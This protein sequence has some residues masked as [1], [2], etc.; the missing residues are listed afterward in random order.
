[1]KALRSPVSALIIALAAKS[2]FSLPQMSDDKDFWRLDPEYKEGLSAGN[3]DLPIKNKDDI[4]KLSKLIKEEQGKLEEN[5]QN[6]Q[7]NRRIISLQFEAMK[8]YLDQMI[9]DSINNVKK[10][11][12]EMNANFNKNLRAITKSNEE[13]HQR[14]EAKALENVEAVARKLIEEKSAT[15]ENMET[16]MKQH[17]DLHDTQLA[18][19]GEKFRYG[20]KGEVDFRISRESVS[21]AGTKIPG[22]NVL[23]SGGRFQVPKGGDGIYE[24]GLSLILDTVHDRSKTG[25]SAKFAFESFQK[26][27]TKVHEETL[28]MSNV[29]TTDRDRVPA[30]RTVLFD[31]VEGDNVVVKQFVLNAETTYKL[32]LCVH[33]VQPS[34]PQEGWSPIN[35]TATLPALR[36]DQTYKKQQIDDFEIGTLSADV[37]EPSIPKT[38]PLSNMEVVVGPLVVTA[39]NAPG[40]L[41]ELSPQES[42]PE[43]GSGAHV[44]DQFD[45]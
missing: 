1:M 10:T 4:T 28:L 36:T 23:R 22:S 25:A 41:F 17:E 31:L 6:D 19:C 34:P 29:G 24:F 40:S 33:L 27:R 7:A 14:L 35:K 11:F 39:K 20:G 42:T 32:T 38:E 18:I 15:L 12:A 13:N 9:G 2:T 45:D 3:Q 26:G 37:E 5:V 16:R 43:F 44:P 30:S 8:K 21:I